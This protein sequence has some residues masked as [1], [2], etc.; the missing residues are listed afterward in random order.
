MS[1]PDGVGLEKVTFEGTEFCNVSAHIAFQCSVIA[2]FHVRRLA[3]YL[4]TLHSCPC[5]LVTEASS[6]FAVSLE[7]VLAGHENWVYG[8]HWQPPFY[9]GSLFLGMNHNTRI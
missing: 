7:T 1:G 2:L 9:K 6:A 8:V 3:L 5:V 4:N